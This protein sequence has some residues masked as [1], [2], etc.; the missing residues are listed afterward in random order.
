MVLISLGMLFGSSLL[1]G[2]CV[3]FGGHVHEIPPSQVVEP[4]PPKMEDSKN[5]PQIES[6][7]AFKKNNMEA[8]KK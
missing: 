5:K 1:T 4:I 6:S 2:C 8:K 3:L 7:A